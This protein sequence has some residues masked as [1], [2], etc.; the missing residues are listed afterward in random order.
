MQQVKLNS[1]IDELALQQ[2]N[3]RPEE[4]IME[5]NAEW[6]NWLVTVYCIWFFL[7]LGILRN[8][9]RGAFLAWLT[10]PLTLLTIWELLL[11]LG[12]SGARWTPSTIEIF[13]AAFTWGILFVIAFMV[14][15]RIE[16]RTYERSGQNLSLTVRRLKALIWCHIIVAF[17]ANLLPRQL[18]FGVLTY[19]DLPLFTILET[20]RPSMGGVTYLPHSVMFF[21]PLIGTLLYG[22]LGCLIGWLETRFFEPAID[23]STQR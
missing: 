5:S 1:A 15:S 4:T 8:R 16:A 14:S 10:G 6:L 3:A 22:S 19:F 7:G 9:S 13:A 18:G 20:M 21:Y 2:L 23:G 11:F 17:I 12:F